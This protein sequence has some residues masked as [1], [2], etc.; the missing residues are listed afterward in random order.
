MIKKNLLVCFTGSVAT[1]K[2][3]E[4]VDLLIESERYNLKLLYTKSGCHFS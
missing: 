4:L 2:D 1:I 3:K